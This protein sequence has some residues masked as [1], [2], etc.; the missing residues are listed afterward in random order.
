MSFWR[1]FDGG[2]AWLILLVCVLVIEFT[3]IGTGHRTLSE[4]FW[5]ATVPG[6]RWEIPLVLLL[7]GLLLVAFGH[8]VGDLWR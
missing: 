7:V 8:F 4:Q 1:F 6:S 3:A 2:G 5:R